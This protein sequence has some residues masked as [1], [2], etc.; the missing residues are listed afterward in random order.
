M[1]KFTCC[2]SLAA[3]DPGSPSEE[4][5]NRIGAT[6]RKQAAGKKAASKEF[7]LFEEFEDEPSLNAGPAEKRRR[8]FG[9]GNCRC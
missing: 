2:R 7:D 6:G 4:F 3:G 8:P 9:A 5:E 1:Q